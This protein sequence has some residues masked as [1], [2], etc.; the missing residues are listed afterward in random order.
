M[1]TVGL[2]N[3]INE[4]IALASKAGVAS[5]ETEPFLKDVSFIEK[6]PT[7]YI[8]SGLVQQNIQISR[9]IIEKNTINM[10]DDKKSFY[11][12]QR[13]ASYESF[14]W[15]LFWFYY[16]SVVVFVGILYI[17]K[18]VVNIYLAFGVVIVL[19]F[20]PLWMIWIE[21]AIMI[22]YRFFASLA[23][24]IPFAWP[25]QMYVFDMPTGQNV[26]F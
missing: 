5:S 8:Y 18:V 15:Y 1:T 25:R 10:T 24:G 14:L 21:R 11:Q 4:E 19:L 13:N 12:V 16:A 20:Y 9:K 26:R 23:F 22:L 3:T 7:P 17:K 6:T 2:V